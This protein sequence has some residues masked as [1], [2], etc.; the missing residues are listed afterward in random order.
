MLLFYVALL[1]G[2]SGINR[3]IC[4][5]ESENIMMIKITIMIIMIVKLNNDV[6]DKSNVTNDNNNNINT[7]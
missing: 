3:Y 1:C 6:D 5:S 7:D 4:N 2:Y